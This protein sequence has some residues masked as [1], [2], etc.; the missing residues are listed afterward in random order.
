[1]PSSDPEQ[2][3][4]ASRPAKP[5]VAGAGLNHRILDALHLR[6]HRLTSTTCGAQQHEVVKAEY[7]SA[8][9]PPAARERLVSAL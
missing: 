1:M 6:S 8:D 4:D 3:R 2:R 5:D 9:P 7:L